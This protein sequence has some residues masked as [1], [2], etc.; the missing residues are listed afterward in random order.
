MGGNGTSFKISDV[1]SLC[2]FSACMKSSKVYH[3]LPLNGLQVEVFLFSWSIVWS[4]YPHLLACGNNAGKDPPKGIETAFVRRWD[5]FWDVHHQRALRITVLNACNKRRHDAVRHGELWN[6]ANAICP[7]LP[8]FSNKK[9]ASFR[10]I[11]FYY[12]F[13]IF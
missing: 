6:P 9:C 4:H 13:R 7:S 3:R 2:I 10:H 5:H 11:Y 8:S 1:S 12:L